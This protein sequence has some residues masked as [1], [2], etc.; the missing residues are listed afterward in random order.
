MPQRADE[1]EHEKE[2]KKNIQKQQFSIMKKK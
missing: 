2:E 1:I